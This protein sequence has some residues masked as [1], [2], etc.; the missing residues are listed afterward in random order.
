MSNETHYPYSGG[1]YAHGVAGMQV[2]VATYAH[3]VHPGSGMHMVDGGGMPMHAGDYMVASQSPHY[4]QAVYPT[5]P[6]QSGSLVSVSRGHFLKGLL[7]GAAATYLI[8][9]DSVQKTAIKSAVRVWSSV[10]GGMEEIKERFRDAEAEIQ[11]SEAAK[12]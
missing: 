5:A 1:G 11:A 8:T 10:Q 12:E 7:I 4:G 2:P 9:N 6:Q 3:H